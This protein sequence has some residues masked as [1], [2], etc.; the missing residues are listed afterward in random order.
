MTPGLVVP[1]LATRIPKALF[2]GAAL[3]P[4]AFGARA[5]SDLIFACLPGKGV[6]NPGLIA[7]QSV[8]STEQIRQILGNCG[9]IGN[10]AAGMQ[11][12]CWDR[13]IS[14]LYLAKL[15]SQAA[16]SQLF[17]AQVL[18]CAWGSRGAI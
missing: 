18:S 4:H 6:W 14:T 3:R 13:L 10:T 9:E 11:R 17:S 15:F 7:R 5:Y 2:N 16:Q 1:R 8:L 12:W